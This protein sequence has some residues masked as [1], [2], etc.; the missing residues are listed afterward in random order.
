V[1]CRIQER[2]EGGTLAQGAAGDYNAHVRTLAER[3]VA[4]RPPIRLDILAPVTRRATG[5][6]PARM[7][8]EMRSYRVLGE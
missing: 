5:C 7:R 1:A 3:L 8:G 4:H 6:L 2:D